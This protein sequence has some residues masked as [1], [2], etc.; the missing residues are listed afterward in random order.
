MQLKSR[1]ACAIPRVKMAEIGERCFPVLLNIKLA[2]ATAYLNMLS[3]SD[4]LS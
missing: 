3:Y 2:H 1:D 4:I